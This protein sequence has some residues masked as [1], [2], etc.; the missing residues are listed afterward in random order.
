MPILPGATLG[1]LGGGQLGRMMAMAARTLGY[2][3]AV[4]DPDPR[5]AARPVVETCLTASFDDAAACE[6]L[7]RLS[8]VVTLEIEKVSLEGLSRAAR[9]VPVRPGR[10]LLEIVQDRGRQKA[11]LQAQGFP[12]GPVEEVHS[13]SAL[14]EVARRLG[15]PLFVKRT[16][17][18]YD[19]RGQAELSRPE[20][21][22]EVWESLGSAP[23]VAEAALELQLE[24]SVCVARRPSGQTAVFPPALNHHEERILAWSLLPG[25]LPP[26]VAQQAEQLAR[27]IAEAIG[28]EGL[29]TVELFLTRDGQLLVNELAP[30]PHNSYHATEVACLTSQFEQAV[31]AV[32]DLPLGTP[33]VTRPSAIMN[34]LGDVWEQGEPPWEEVLALPGVRLHLYGKHEARP[35][36]KMGHLSAVGHTPEEALALL[37][38]ARRR[39]ERQGTR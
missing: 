16:W 35:G 30:R 33:E 32:C 9:H 7:A 21:A 4:L 26:G 8:D 24:L 6:E 3:V 13:A 19:G 10:A 5:C 11:W 36:R 29:L 25:P 14:E 31:R 18:G 38:E 1:I 20:Q 39:L 22:P 34:L 37:Q 2:R 23:C 15:R 17:G 28:L 27:R 12:V